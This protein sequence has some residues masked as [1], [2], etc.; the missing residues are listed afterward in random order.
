ML[1]ISS[2][3]RVIKSLG[4]KPT[5]KK[6][7]HSMNVVEQSL[8]NRR[9]PSLLMK[10]DRELFLSQSYTVNKILKELT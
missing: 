10:I 6:V 7:L 3:L 1:S 4:Y 9:R 2:E 8:M 5:I